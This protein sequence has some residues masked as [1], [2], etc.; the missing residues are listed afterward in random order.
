MTAGFNVAT[1]PWIPVRPAAGGQRSDV[2]LRTA[3]TDAHQWAGYPD[4]DTQFGPAILRILTAVTIRATDLADANDDESFEQALSYLRGEGRL[5]PVRVD[6]YFK[7][8]HDEFWLFPPANDT[9]R[10]RWLQDDRLSAMPASVVTE[11]G[12][13]PHAAPS[14]AWGNQ[15]V[16]PPT[17][18]AAARALLAFLH[19]GRGGGGAKHPDAAN[20][21]D[22]WQVGRLRGTVSFHPCGATLF[23]TLL[24]HAV[25]ADGAPFTEVGL[26]EWEQTPR[27]AA[28]DP[29]RQ[30]S[31]LLEQLTGRWEKTAWLHQ[32]DRT[33]DRVTIA[34]GRRRPDTVTEADP[35]AALKRIEDK[36]TKQPITVPLRSRPGRAIWRDFPSL[37]AQADTA[38]HETHILRALQ[39]GPSQSRD[40]IAAWVVAAHRPDNAK[41]NGWDLSSVAPKT[42]LDPATEDAVDHFVRLTEDTAKQLRKHTRNYL[43]AVGCDQS[44]QKSRLRRAETLFWSAMEQQFRRI[45]NNPAG[46]ETHAAVLDAAAAGYDAAADDVAAT[47]AATHRSSKDRDSDLLPAAVARQIHRHRLAAAVNSLF[48]K[49]SSP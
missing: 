41:D 17:P 14:Y 47:V 15:I 22:G 33:V 18:A 28:T 48:D 11:S 10:R 3:L 40:G 9:G 1:D 46:A 42:L 34:T 8:W 35:Y 29:I 49:E 12:L 39:N 38:R 7:R 16:E 23:D 5:D 31:T 26:P 36:E 43:S 44:P 24:L 13:M 25:P 27:P 32:T 30:P 19:Y 2:S 6:R 45:V 20:P 37:R 4:D 21:K